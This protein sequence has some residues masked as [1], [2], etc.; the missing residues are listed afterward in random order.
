MTSVVV[1]SELSLKIIFLSFTSRFPPNCGVVSFTKS[2]LT[3]VH[4]RFPDP[5]DFKTCVPLES[6]AGRVQ[7]RLVLIVAGA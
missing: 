7:T 1:P 5:S 6:V 4:P 2:L 3:V